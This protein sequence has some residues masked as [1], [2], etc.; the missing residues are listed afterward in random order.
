MRFTSCNSALDLLTFSC[1][2]LSKP[3]DP[4]I[5][6]EHNSSAIL[7]ILDQKKI[8]KICIV[9]NLKI[10]SNYFY[11]VLGARTRN[12]DIFAALKNEHASY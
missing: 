12:S 2:L 1:V 9:L 10:G 7:Q 6:N 5:F 3:V 11:F 4:M 8:V